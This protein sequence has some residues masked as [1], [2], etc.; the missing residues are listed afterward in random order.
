MGR[1][2]MR[3]TWRGKR[4][5]Q[6]GGASLKEEAVRNAGQMGEMVLRRGWRENEMVS[7]ESLEFEFGT[8]S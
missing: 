6:G 3:Q 8:G 5:E 1:E 7:G 4:Q 2:G